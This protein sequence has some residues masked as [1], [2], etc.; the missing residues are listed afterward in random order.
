MGKMPVT[1]LGYSLSVDLSK[2]IMVVAKAPFPQGP[3]S[4]VAYQDSAMVEDGGLTVAGVM[5][6]RGY[7]DTDVRR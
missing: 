4:E 2:G 1:I 5:L 6:D 7:L 3:A